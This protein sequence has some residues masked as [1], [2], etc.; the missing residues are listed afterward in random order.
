LYH[1]KGAEEGGLQW[2]QGGGDFSSSSSE[3]MLASMSL[4]SNA[5]M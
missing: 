3:L 2:P 4:L 1:L 5:L